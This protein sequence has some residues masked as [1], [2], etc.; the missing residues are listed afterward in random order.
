MSLVKNKSELFEIE[1]TLT[2]LLGNEYY[3]HGLI[4]D[5]NIICKCGADMNI[6]TCNK[7]KLC[8]NFDQVH[9]FDKD[10]KISFLK[11]EDK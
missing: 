7:V 8:L 2:E 5:E 9:L 6:E 11:G 1:I 4:G 3:I 10:T